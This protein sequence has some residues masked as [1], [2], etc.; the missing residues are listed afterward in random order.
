MTNIGHKI[1]PHREIYPLSHLKWHG[2]MLHPYASSCCR[3]PQRSSSLTQRSRSTR[4]V[5]NQLRRSWGSHCVAF[6]LPRAGVRL[7]GSCSESSV[8]GRKGEFHKKKESLI[9]IH[10]SGMW[11]GEQNHFR[12]QSMVTRIGLCLG[13]VRSCNQGSPGV[14]KPRGVLYAESNGLSGGIGSGIDM[15]SNLRRNSGG[16]D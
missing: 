8:P 5:F 12:H 1:E 15:R 2:L 14:L 13:I 4:E 3:F 7:V 6:F 11:T 16:P 10:C 9:S